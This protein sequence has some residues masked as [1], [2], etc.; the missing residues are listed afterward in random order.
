MALKRTRTTSKPVKTFRIDRSK[1]RAG[2][3]G[4][5]AIGEGCASLLN[6]EGFMC[7]LGHTTSQEGFQS[8]DL[9]GKGMPSYISRLIETPSLFSAVEGVGYHGHRRTT[10]FGYDAA[11][12]NDHED[13]TIPTKEKR[14]R[15]LFKRNGCRIVFYGKSVP[16]ETNRKYPKS[17]AVKA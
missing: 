6:S 15:E 3:A 8:C 5:Y 10:E 13:E 17:K 1:W 2:G 11:G 12:I 16:Y 7:C 9:L 14:L 4:K